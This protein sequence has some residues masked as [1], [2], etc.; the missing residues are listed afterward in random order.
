MVGDIKLQSVGINRIPWPCND[1]C[2]CNVCLASSVEWLAHSYVWPFFYK[3]QLII[4]VDESATHLFLVGLIIAWWFT[5]WTW[6]LLHSSTLVVAADP[7]ESA[8]SSSQLVSSR[9]ALSSRGVHWLSCHIVKMKVQRC[10]LNL[11]SAWALFS[12]S[13]QCLGHPMWVQGHPAQCLFRAPH[14]PI[15]NQKLAQ[16]PLYLVFGS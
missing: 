10:E 12:V 9:V 16:K 8:T 15:K 4:A 3:S 7:S 14:T 13:L 6:P 11:L 1:P 5:L 2:I